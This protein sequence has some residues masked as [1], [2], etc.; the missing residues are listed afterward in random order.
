[1]AYVFPTPGAAPTNPLRRPRSSRVAS[2]RSASGEGRRS[3]SERSLARVVLSVRWAIEGAVERE[4]VYPRFAEDTELPAL[5]ILRNQRLD[6][7]QPL[8]AQ[9]GHPRGLITGGGGTDV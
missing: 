9:P 1:M 8:A 3:V 2:A 4:H 6:L 7:G 5:R